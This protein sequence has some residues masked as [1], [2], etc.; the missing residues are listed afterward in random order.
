MNHFTH[1]G[2]RSDAMSG[3][4]LWVAH[5]IRNNCVEGAEGLREDKS[6]SYYNN[7]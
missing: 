1:F 6:V 7:F 2:T 5:A 3:N 4:V